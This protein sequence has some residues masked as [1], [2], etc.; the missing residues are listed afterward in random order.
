MTTTQE[1]RNYNIRRLSDNMTDTEWQQFFAQMKSDI[2]P[3]GKKYMTKPGLSPI[4]DGT[5]Y[6][7]ETS[8]CRYR[9]FINNIL[10][11]IRCD[12]F[13]YC[14]YIYQ[15]RDLLRHEPNL[16]SRYLPYWDCFQV[17]IDTPI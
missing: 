11:A 10:Q 6:H 16:Q 13:D 12:E 8:A 15:I 1:I 14:F 7:G 4:K 17:W 5:E 9:Q 3:I 2:K